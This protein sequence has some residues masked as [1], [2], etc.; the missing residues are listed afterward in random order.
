MEMEDQPQELKIPKGKYRHIMECLGS[1]WK[2]LH[3]LP[4]TFEHSLCE[5]NI[6]KLYWI[7]KLYNSGIFNFV[8]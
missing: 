2:K 3:K 6:K 1:V 5:A 4:N 7:H 8:H